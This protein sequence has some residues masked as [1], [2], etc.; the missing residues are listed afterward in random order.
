MKLKSMFAYISQA[1][2]CFQFTKKLNNW[3]SEK[4]YLFVCGYLLAVCGRLLVVCGRLLEICGC[5]GSFAGGLRCFVVLCGLCL[6]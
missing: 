3:N 5:L 6:F 1:S 4:V 2:P